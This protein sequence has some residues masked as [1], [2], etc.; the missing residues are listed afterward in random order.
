MCGQIHY[1]G[2]ALGYNLGMVGYT[3]HGTGIWSHGDH[4]FRALNLVFSILFTIEF[5]LRFAAL[6][7]NSLKCRWMWID[8]IVVLVDWICF[9]DN[10]AIGP[11][12]MIFRMFRLIRILRILKVLK[13]FK[14]VGTLFLLVKSIQS[15]SFALMWSFLL[16]FVVQIT[17][18]VVLCQSFT[19]FLNDE[20]KP[21]DTRKQLFR[22]FGTVMN[23]IVTM[24]DISHGNWVIS[25]RF[26]YHEVHTIFG[27]FYVLYRCCCMFAVTTV[28]TAVFIAETNRVAASDDELAIAKKQRAKDAQCTK[29][30]EL[31]TELDVSNDGFVS[32]EEF[33]DLISDGL[34][35]TWLETLEIDTHDLTQLFAL[36]A[37]EENRFSINDFVASLSIIKGPAKSVDMLQVTTVI[38]RLD[39]KL[40][41][42]VQNWKNTL[43]Q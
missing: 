4:F 20:T 28:I 6:K 35:T 11:D 7:L 38:G 43:S 23:S 13:R 9:L 15:S 36:L 5:V 42:M 14:A 17:M 19:G 3:R 37:D 31:F 18:G 29:L 8:F 2:L 21:L 32:W 26:L 1:Q 25:C 34:L 39:R 27:A 16:L 10:W 40:D 41:L 22:Y 30:R 12:P 33:Q 24:F